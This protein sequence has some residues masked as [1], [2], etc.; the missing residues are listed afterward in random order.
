MQD[1]ENNKAGE[2]SSNSGGGYDGPITA[3]GVIMLAVAEFPA[4]AA[5]AAAFVAQYIFK[6]QP[7]DLCIWQRYPYGGVIV[8]LTVSTAFAVINLRDAKKHFS[9]VKRALNLSALLYATSGAIGAYHVAVENKWVSGPTGCSSQSGA[10]MSTAD[11]LA[12]IMN[13]PVVMCDNV[14]FEF[15]GVSMAGWNMIYATACVAFCLFLV[16]KLKKYM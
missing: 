13:T 10:D 14:P 12:Q 4:F 6:M 11:L 16:G 15:L 8:V 7:C 5:L 3:P 1:N 9:I 2:Q